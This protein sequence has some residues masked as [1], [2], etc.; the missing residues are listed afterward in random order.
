M[1]VMKFG[2]ASVKDAAGIRNVADII[3]HHRT[4]PLLVVV[5][6]MD[7]TTNH[8][9][10]L[11]Y[12]ARDNQEAAAW[13]QFGRIRRFH[14]GQ[15]EALFDVA[16]AEAVVARVEPFF[17]EMEKIVRGILLLEEFPARTYDRIVAYGELLSTVIVAA[18]LEAHG[19]DCRW[20]DARQ[21][22]KTDATYQQAGVI[23]SLT[24]QNIRREVLPHMQAGRTFVVQGFIG[25]TNE[26]RTTT[27]GREGSDYTGAIFAHC[28]GAESLTVWKDVPGVLNGDPRIRE[29]TVKLDKL[30]YEEAVEMTF[31][32][33]SVIHPKTIKPIYTKGI[34]LLVKC[35]LDVEAEGTIISTQPNEQ[36]IPAYI[37]KKGQAFLRIQ[38]K[39]FSFMEERLIQEISE[40]IYKT[41]V[42]LNLVQNSAISLMLCVDDKPAVNNL[43]ALLLD[44][45]E[46]AVF[47]DL[48]LHT[49]INFTIKDLKDTVDAMMVQQHANKLY[50]VR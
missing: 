11:A 1:L 20:L 22:V 46:V 30:S 15:I 25:S 14:L 33:A 5:S 32:G 35:F 3:L 26:G 10:T 18:Y 50:L 48:Q 37:V 4:H 9:E 43:I 13:E 41:G 8:L 28:L 47:R 31:Y 42:K 7:K 40:Q 44:R 27:L 17:E 23:W 12:L 2:G 45:F 19:H 39:D 34:P 16:A 36:S 6:A 29:H 38:P 24:E 49:I 21:L